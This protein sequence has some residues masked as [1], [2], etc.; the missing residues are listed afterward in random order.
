MWIIKDNAADFDVGFL[1]FINKK[2]EFEVSVNNMTSSN[3]NT[4]GTRSSTSFTI[5]EL[6]NASEHLKDS[7][8]IEYKSRPKFANVSSLNKISIANYF[9]QSALASK[10][11]GIKAIGYCSALEALFS[12]GEN[13]E[14]SH[15]LSERISK[16]LESQAEQ[17]KALYRIV[18][19]VYDIR[20]KVV[21]G[22]TY[23]PQKEDELA[24]LIKQA[25]DICRRVMIYAFTT[26]EGENIFHKS[27]EDLEEYFIDL[28]LN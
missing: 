21:H 11:L 18:K 8:Y 4:E 6:S 25:D 5:K 2:G 16:F 9:I 17:R 20:S 14:L 7:I 12:N 23:K 27:R 3:F 24:G 19:R 28:V 26:P 1:Q 22:A 13:T 15:K 10:D